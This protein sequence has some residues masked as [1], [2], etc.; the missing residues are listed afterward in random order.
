MNKEE[1]STSKAPLSEEKDEQYNKAKR[2][3][4]EGQY[5]KKYSIISH[6]IF[7]A[8]TQ[9]PESELIE[10]V[11]ARQAQKRPCNENEK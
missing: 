5:A 2:K 6:Q 11:R 3:R 8:S 7:A 1:C 9:P 10:K 4:I